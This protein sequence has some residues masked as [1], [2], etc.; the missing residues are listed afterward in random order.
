[1]NHFDWGQPYP[2]QQRDVDPKPLSDFTQRTESK[3]DTDPLGWEHAHGQQQRNLDP[4]QWSG[5]NEQTS[6]VSRTGWDTDVSCDYTLEKSPTGIGTDVGREHHIPSPHN[7]HRKEYAAFDSDR[8]TD[9]DGQP[10]EMSEEDEELVRKRRQ[11]QMIEEQILLKKASIAMKKIEP[12]L[13][14][15][16]PYQTFSV[17]KEESFAPD[18]S[19]DKNKPPVQLE[20]GCSYSKQS[21]A[22]KAATLKDR[23]N[24]ILQQKHRYLPTDHVPVCDFPHSL[25]TKLA[26]NFAERM[27]SSSRSNSGL[28]R[29]DHPLKLR[30]KALIRQRRGNAPA[31]PSNGEVPDVKPPSHS[32]SPTSAALEKNMESEGFQRFLNILNK[33]VDI[34]LLTRIVNDDSEELPDAGKLLN[35]Q[36]P[37]AHNKSDVPYRSESQGSSRGALEQDQ[38]RSKSRERKSEPP[39]QKASSTETQSLREEESILRSEKQDS[40]VCSSSNSTSPPRLEDQQRQQLQNILKT[41]GLSLEAEEISKLS[42]RTQ[43][44]LYGKRHDNRQHGDRERERRQRSIPRHHEN[45]SSSSSISGS[46]SPSHRRRSVSTDSDSRDSKERRRTS[47]CRQSRESSRDTA[48]PQG[49]VMD[50]DKERISSWE[51]VP[52]HHPYPTNP[53]YPSSQPAA[54]AALQQYNSAQHSHYTAHHSSTYN[55]ATNS[56]WFY[57]HGAVPA[58]PA[59]SGYFYQQNTSYNYFGSEGTPNIAYPYSHP[60]DSHSLEDTHLMLN[61]DLSASEGQSGQQLGRHCLKVVPLKQRRN[62][63]SLMPLTTFQKCRSKKKKKKRNKH[64][65]QAAA[66]AVAITEAPV[67]TASATAVATLAASITTASTAAASTAATSTMAAASKA[68]ASKAAATKQVAESQ[69]KPGVPKPAVSATTEKQRSEDK[70]QLTEEEIKANLKKKLDAFNQLMKQKGIISAK[71]SLT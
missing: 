20:A 66:T 30:V 54:E 64:A 13:K 38:S 33:G 44:R 25:S 70:K 2:R 15:K 8:N 21:A 63:G 3:W 36:P 16:I 29:E 59:P 22:S 24:V 26:S 47:E 10:I 6:K 60:R 37:V 57:T 71:N 14:N 51:S 34:N 32:Q 45:S 28:R 35:I 19:V 18:M 39:S 68:V 56:A 1:M 55:A 62:Q 53:A 49:P 12:F 41:L 50:I 40:H 48:K 17:E 65:K 31:L 7:R 67:T 52:G 5:I 42:D 43:E 4:K 11:L 27:N 69:V 58:P 46:L 61:P 23:V 9:P